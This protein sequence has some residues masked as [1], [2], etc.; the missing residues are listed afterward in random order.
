MQTYDEAVQVFCQHLFHTLSLHHQGAL[1]M[2]AASTSEVSVNYQT[3]WHNVTED[4]H[5]H[6]KNVFLCIHIWQYFPFRWSNTLSLKLLLSLTVQLQTGVCL[7]ILTQIRPQ[8]TFC[9]SLAGTS[10]YTLYKQRVYI[11]VLY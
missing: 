11:P 3:T 2:E 6:V 5:L 1:T 7:I 10:W 8:G 4:S 9:T